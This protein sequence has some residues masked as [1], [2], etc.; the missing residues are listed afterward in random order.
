MFVEEAIDAIHLYQMLDVH[1]L[2]EPLLRHLDLP[3]VPLMARVPLTS[4]ARRLS[5]AAKQ[6]I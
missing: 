3:I 2:V 5:L 6:G 4:A 1:L